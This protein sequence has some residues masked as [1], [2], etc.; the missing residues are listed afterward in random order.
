M[1]IYHDYRVNHDNG[2]GNSPRAR[3]FLQYLLIKN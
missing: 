2:D 3:A 1:E